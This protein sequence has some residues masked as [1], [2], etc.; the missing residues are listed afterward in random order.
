MQA[1]LSSMSE[2]VLAVDTEGHILHFNTAA[3]KSCSG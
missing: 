3:A 2:G 1:V